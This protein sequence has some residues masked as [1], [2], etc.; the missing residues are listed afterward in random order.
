[1][2]EFTDTK[3]YKAEKRRPGSCRYT[4]YIIVADISVFQRTEF[5]LKTL[6]EKAQT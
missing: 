1:V 5:K 6:T 2:V 3:E 4:R